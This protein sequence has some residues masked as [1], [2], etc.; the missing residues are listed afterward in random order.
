MKSIREDYKPL[1]LHPKDEEAF[2]EGPRTRWFEFIF[3][4]QVLKEFIK[5]FRA[6]HFVGPCVTVFGSARFKEGHIYYKKAYDVGKRLAEAGVTVLTGG[7]PGIMEAANRGAFENGGISVGCNIELPLEQHANAYMHRWVTIKY[8]FVRK[9][10]LV[11]YSF[12]FIVLPGGMGT[13]DEFFETLTLIQTGSIKDFP[14]VLIGRDYFEPLYKLL[15]EM[16]E[17]GTISEHDL[18]LVLLTDDIDEAYKHVQDYVL[19]N[20][21]VSRMKPSRWLREK[22]LKRQEPAR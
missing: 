5:G 2:L 6:L 7:G 16:L 13:M 22:I 8:F 14:V 3:V 12:A 15:H 11:K 10:L 17:N 20:Y 18:K 21:K 1:T 19:K 4:V 9:V